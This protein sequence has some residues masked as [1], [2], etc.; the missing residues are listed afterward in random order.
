[1]A[2]A[3]QH[4]GFGAA[5]PEGVVQPAAGGGI[6]VPSVEVERHAGTIARLR[7]RDTAVPFGR[8]PGEEGGVRLRPHAAFQIGSGNLCH[9]HLIADHLPGL[10]FAHGSRQHI[11]QPAAL[12]RTDQFAILLRNGRKELRI[13][14]GVAGFACELQLLCAGEQ[15]S[16][17]HGQRREVAEFEAAED[18]LGRPSRV[19]GADRHPFEIGLHRGCLAGHP[20]TLG[21]GLVIFRPAYPA[22]IGDFMIV[23][24]ADEGG[25]GMGGLH[26][27]VGLHL[28]MAA[29]V[30]GQ[31][32][33]LM[34]R[35]GQAAEP[36][37]DVA[38]IAILTIFID[39]IAEHQHGIE[40]LLPGHVCI[41]VVISAGIKLA[42]GDGEHD[43]L[44]RAD[45]QCAEAAFGRDATVRPLEAVP[46]IAPG[47]ETGDL[48]LHRPV[49]G[50]TGDCRAATCRLRAWSRGHM[51]ADRDIARSFLGRTDASPDHGSIGSRVA[52][53][54]AM[55]KAY[56]PGETGAHCRSRG[57]AG[58]DGRARCA[59]QAK[60]AAPVHFHVV[61]LPVPPQ[62][63][64]RAVSWIP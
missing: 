17:Q 39:V 57:A 11:L 54:D 25:A 46:V 9:H 48:D 28:R 29:A 27:G 16:F 31:R 56:W 6:T 19:G 58:K 47:F 2:V 64:T 22:V 63:P 60:R 8:Q 59:E 35:I 1:M 34:R 53:G 50:G 3:R 44:N 41:G 12:L 38:A 7:S 62:P 61:H 14:I 30:V 24:D 10:S 55:R 45:G 49:G 5:G 21:R 52:A 4:N 42:G 51:P 37:P 33:R 18:R 40:A 32:H 26:V 36:P 43:I 15:P 23:P 13:G 20:V